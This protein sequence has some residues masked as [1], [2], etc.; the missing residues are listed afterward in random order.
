MS[1]TS[2]PSGSAGYKLAVGLIAAQSI[3]IMTPCV[4]LI[5][6]LPCVF[7][8]LPRAAQ[9]IA[10]DAS[11]A[12]F[13]RA[14][15][16]GPEVLAMRQ[17]A[18]A[19]LGGVAQHADGLLRAED[20][21]C[22]ICLGEFVPGESI[23]T[24]PC[25]GRHPFHAL[26]VDKWLMTKDS[27]PNC[28]ALLFEQHDDLEAGPRLQ[29]P[30]GPMPMNAP[31]SMLG[32]GFLFGAAAAFDDGPHE[33]GEDGPLPPSSAAVPPSAPRGGGAS[34]ASAASLELPG[35]GGSH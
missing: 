26:C 23:R 18:I 13:G 17:L 24:L 3:M 8:C 6:V 29:G 5:F 11:R 4:L 14:A 28:R 12:Q 25:P 33:D 34:A 22:S 27:C 19:K 16:V 20:A 15:Q 1:A 9:N 10:V 31:D 32:A 21:A 35:R 2:G 30:A 7:L